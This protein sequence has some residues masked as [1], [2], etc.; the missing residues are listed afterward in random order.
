VR[1]NRE[2][3]NTLFFLIRDICLLSV[4]LLLAACSFDYGDSAEGDKNKP[5][6]IM[7]D[8]EYVR[9]RGGD[10]LARFKAEHAERW[11]DRQTMEIRDF[12]FEQLEKK[13]EEIN[14]EGRAGK[15]SVKLESGDISLTGGVR[16]N[17]ESEEIIINTGGLEWKDK[18]KIL[19]GAEGDEVHVERPD[20]TSFTGWGFYADM[21]KRSWTFSGEVKGT[22]VEEEDEEEAEEAEKIEGEG[23]SLIAEEEAGEQPEQAQPEITRPEVTKPEITRPE[24]TRP[25]VT[26][27]EITRPEVTKPETTKP[28]AAQP[29]P[30]VPEV[31][32]PEDK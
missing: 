17:I 16:I 8:L 23:E 27:P 30:V 32:L 26:K 21:R 18:E 15:A 12:Y 14:A 13:G 2:H 28:E 11:E 4:V 25:E 10:P 24:V 19:Y 22:Y 31:T 20:G 3:K 6:I 29:K 5:D 7:E 9:V 1:H